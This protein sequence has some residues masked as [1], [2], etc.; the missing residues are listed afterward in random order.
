MLG[1][2]RLL[3][4]IPE[5]NDGVQEGEIEN[6]P[7]AQRIARL[8]NCSN[9]DILKIMRAVNSEGNIN[10]RVA[11][12]QGAHLEGADLEGA[13]LREAIGYEKTN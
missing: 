1:Q 6:T 8:M 7:R 4:G 2:A 13:D 10:L 9:R 12:L 11:D 5:I 3:A